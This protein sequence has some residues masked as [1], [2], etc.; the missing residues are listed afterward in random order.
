MHVIH[1]ADGPVTPVPIERAVERGL[2]PRGLAT[3]GRVAAVGVG[4]TGTQQI[5][6][7][8]EV[9]GSDEGL[10]DDERASAVREVVAEPVAAVLV[11][12]RIP[13]DIRHNAKIDRAAVAVTAT[14]LLS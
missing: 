7:V 1:T 4:P 2:G 3:T 13:V 12:E 9:E 5:V 11:T 14:E 6:V 8:L 10:A